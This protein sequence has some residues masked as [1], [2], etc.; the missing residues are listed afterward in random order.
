MF[1]GKYLAGINRLYEQGKFILQGRLQQLHNPV[2]WAEYM[3]QLR[4]I[5]WVV[6]GKPPFG[7]PGQVLKYLARYTHR[8]AI[9]NRRLIG[10]KNG[11]VTFRYKDY[12][13][14]QRQ[15]VMRLPAV[16]FIRRFLLHSL[17]KGFMRIRHYGLLANRVRQKCLA[18]CRRLLRHVERAASQ[19]EPTGTTTH[20]DTGFACPKCN[21]TTT[22]VIEIIP[23]ARAGPVRLA[24]QPG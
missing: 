11:Q 18:Q 20:R 16:E 14:G 5:E 7:S 15:R 24:I 6:Y 21:H 12:R 4:D 2:Q 1:R 17:P 22:I 8:V 9:S 13:R 3:G 23:P 19:G 10:L